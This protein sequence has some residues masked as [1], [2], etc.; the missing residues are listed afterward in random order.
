MQKPYT[1]KPLLL[2]SDKE[3]GRECYS[4]IGS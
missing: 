4:V 1:A 2:Q 3:T